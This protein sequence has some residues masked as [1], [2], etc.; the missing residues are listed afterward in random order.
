MIDYKKKVKGVSELIETINSLKSENKKIVHCHGCFDL[1]HPGHL[2]YLGFAKTQ[3]DVLVVSITGDDFMGKGYKKPFTTSSLRAEGLAALSLVDLVTINESPDAL[4]LIKQ[5][6]PD[7]YIKGNEYAN[8]RKNH[9]GF[10]KEKEGVESYG[11]KVIYSSGDMVFSSTDILEELLVRDDMIIEKNRS[12]LIKHGIDKEKIKNTIKNYK[13]SKILVIGDLF[14]E[15]YIICDK[16]K[17]SNDAPILNLKVIKEERHFSGV[18]TIAKNIISLGGNLDIMCI[19]GKNDCSKNAIQ[20]LEKRLDKKINLF[21]L[22]NYSLPI[23]KGIFS[24]NQKLMEINFGKN[25]TF[26]ETSELKFLENIRNVIGDYEG[27]IIC[28]YGKGT[29]TPNITDLL[30]RKTRERNILTTVMTGEDATKN[31]SS[32]KTLDFAL[33]TEEEARMS[34]NNFSDGMD[35][36]SRE[37]FSKCKH[38]YLIINL[39]K[40]GIIC[41]RPAIDAIEGTSSDYASYLPPLSEKISGITSEK[42]TLISAITLSMA[43]GG[44][45]YIGL[46]IGNLVSAIKKSKIKE[47]YISPIDLIDV[48]ENRKEFNQ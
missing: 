22:E 23:K 46:Y 39:G 14:L 38:S 33:C 26:D 42:E 32:Y 37:V 35:F 28:D 1:L 45:V 30:I 24:N 40:K 41:Y 48:L 20:D 9:P 43:S 6:R 25:V 29:I 31:F 36:L 18:A 17:L 12:F 19:A 13:N 7:V 5:I 11:G 3:G 4:N 10:L 27:V 8:E 16:P 21:E 2:R 44:D 47:D 34:V 15:D